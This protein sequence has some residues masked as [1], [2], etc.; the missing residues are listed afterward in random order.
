MLKQCLGLNLG[1]GLSIVSG[2]SLGLSVASCLGLDLG[3]V[4][5]TKAKNC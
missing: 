4:D 3:D 1:G 2:L 5:E